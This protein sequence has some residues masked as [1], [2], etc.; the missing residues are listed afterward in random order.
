MTATRIDKI[1][2]VLKL[3]FTG[4]VKVVEARQALQ[5]IERLVAELQPG[6]RLLTDLTGLNLMEQDCVPEI[7]RTMDLMNQKGVS[8]VVRVIPDPHK[9]IGFNIM[10][11]FHYRHGLRIVT[12]DTMEQAE[13]VLAG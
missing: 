10:S 7:S 4:E 3:S 6:F 12:C 1:S 11:L 8:L 5:E 13:K 2:N 9:D